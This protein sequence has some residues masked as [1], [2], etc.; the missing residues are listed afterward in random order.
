ME[1]L[2]LRGQS[3]ATGLPV[4]EFL[5]EP[6]FELG[7]LSADGAMREVE[8]V[9]RRRKAAEAGCGLKGAQSIEWRQWWRAVIHMHS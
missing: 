7:H 8:V 5:A 2:P 6:V 3:N 4:K 1:A 9:R